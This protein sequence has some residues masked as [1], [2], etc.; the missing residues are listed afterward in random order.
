MTGPAPLRYLTRDEVW[1]INAAVLGQEGR[2]ALLR[3]RAALEGALMRPQMAAHYE[4]ADVVMQ[5]AILIA[6]IAFAH[7]FL[8]GNKRTATVA[9]SVFLDLN[10]YIID[11]APTDDTLGR[12]VEALVAYLDSADAAIGRLCDWLRP[13]V[14]PR[15]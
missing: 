8:D 11:V 1:A 12:Q 13:H 14:A 4:Q 2:P 9:G 15:S 6:A 10:G 3:D 5:A 7:A